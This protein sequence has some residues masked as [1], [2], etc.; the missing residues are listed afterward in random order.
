MFVLSITVVIVIRFTDISTSSTVFHGPWS[1]IQNQA[2]AQFRGGGGGDPDKQAMVSA[3][4]DFI[5][6]RE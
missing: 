1:F 2:C 5:Q 4:K 6:F 3:L